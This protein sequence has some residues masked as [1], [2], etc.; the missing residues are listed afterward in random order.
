MMAMLG[1]DCET[2]C[3]SNYYLVIQFGNFRNEIINVT[4]VIKNAT[5]RATG[6]IVASRDLEY[7]GR[8]DFEFAEGLD[9]DAFEWRWV[10][11]R[12]N[13]VLSA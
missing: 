6:D 8:V 3:Y 9:V 11:C 10:V 4:N 2:K 12:P 13:D 5:S 1:C 7:V